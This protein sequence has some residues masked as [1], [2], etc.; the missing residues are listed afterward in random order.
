[1]PPRFNPIGRF[2]LSPASARP[3]AYSHGLEYHTTTIPREV[4]HFP[5]QGESTPPLDQSTF[6]TRGN[7]SPSGP[8]NPRNVYI[9][10]GLNDTL[11]V[12]NL[13]PNDICDWNKPS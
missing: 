11:C 13:T 6:T 10:P 12:D 2:A 5:W 8:P 3:S 4:D 9:K 1:M 7:P